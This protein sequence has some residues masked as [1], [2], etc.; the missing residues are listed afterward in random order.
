MSDLYIIKTTCCV[1]PNMVLWDRINLSCTEIL[2]ADTLRL[3]QLWKKIVYFWIDISHKRATSST[4]I[5][6]NWINC[7]LYILN[8]LLNLQ[9]FP[10]LNINFTEPYLGPQYRSYINVQFLKCKI[11]E[12]LTGAI[13]KRFSKVSR[14]WR[15]AAYHV[16][17]ASFY[18]Q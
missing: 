17:L 2:K 4:E 9:N 3:Q 18:L 11:P 13:C 12:S 7:L 15:C 14:R 16:P 5:R 8:V 6:A 10:L 1:Q